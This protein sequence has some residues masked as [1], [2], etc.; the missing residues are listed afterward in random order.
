MRKKKKKK[1][2]MKRRGEKMKRWRE[3]M[4][5]KRMRMKKMEGMFYLK[6][7]N[8]EKR[9][10]ITKAIDNPDDYYLLKLI[11][12]LSKYIMIGCCEMN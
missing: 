12:S 4:S 8:K 7:K 1:K 3:K 11:G 9:K 10:M 5:M 6:K 2:G